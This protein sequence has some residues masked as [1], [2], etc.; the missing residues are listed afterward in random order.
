MK[1]IFATILLLSILLSLF[2][3]QK[4]E[5]SS[6]DNDGNTST[7]SDEIEQIDMNGYVFKMSVHN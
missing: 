7:P 4:N 5:P 3:C 6:L 1:K 2:A